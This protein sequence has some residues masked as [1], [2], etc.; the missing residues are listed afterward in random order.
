MLFFLLR[1]FNHSPDEDTLN[2]IANDQSGK[3]KVMQ[4]RTGTKAKIT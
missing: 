1:D 4:Q 2:K 3:G